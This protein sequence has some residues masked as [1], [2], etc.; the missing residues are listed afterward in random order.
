[1]ENGVWRYLCM[2]RTV[3][4]EKARAELLPIENDPRVPMS[5]SYAMYRGKISPDDVFAAAREGDPS[6]DSL[7][8]RLFYAHLYVGL[9]HDAAA[10]RDG[11]KP[12]I[13]KA[14]REYRISHYMGD[15]ATVHNAR[16]SNRGAKPK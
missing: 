6:P 14:A 3:G 9:F 1:M 15:V 16:L 4:V 13:A 11:A 5:E 12:H 2:A 7:K 10:R 8:T